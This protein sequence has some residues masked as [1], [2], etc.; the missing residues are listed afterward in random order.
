MSKGYLILKNLKKIRFLP[1]HWLAELAAL[2]QIYFLPIQEHKVQQVQ[3]VMKY[4][5]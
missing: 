5:L 2:L 3:L 1:E 4:G